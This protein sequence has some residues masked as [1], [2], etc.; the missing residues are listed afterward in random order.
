METATE[1]KATD[2]QKKPE[3]GEEIV[4]AIK[5]LKNHS[6]KSMF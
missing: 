4:I 3:N 6:E 5:G 2:T 1:N